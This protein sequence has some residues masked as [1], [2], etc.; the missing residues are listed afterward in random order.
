VKT[1]FPALLLLLAAAVPADGPVLVDWIAATVNDTA[2]PE[3]AVRRAI[4]LSAMPRRPGETD[5]AYRARVVDELI[6]ERLQYEDAL[7]FGPS[8]P[9]AAEVGAALE[10][11]RQRIRAEG[12]D[13]DAEF[14]AAGMS[15]EE[16]RASLERQLVVRRY[17]RERFRPIALAD[18]ERARE[19][20]EARYVPERRAAGQPV[21]PFEEVAE[22]IRARAQERAF[23]E[24]L[25][26][27]TRELKEKARITVYPAAPA[28]SRS[29][30]TVLATLPAPTVTPTRR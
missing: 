25:E 14:A 18:E 12:R 13:P 5:A 3:S 24:E 23:E 20:Y 9:D 16:V 10:E 29:T 27:W 7:R 17:L 2:I 4:V 28:P 6:V 21:P 30:P 22:E 26:R 8:P 19:E 15:V 1:A 11:V